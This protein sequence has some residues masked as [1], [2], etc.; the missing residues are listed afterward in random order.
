MASSPERS[1]RP[2][3]VGVNTVLWTAAGV[4]VCSWWCWRPVRG[5]GPARGGVS[6]GRRDLRLL[7]LLAVVVGLV[8]AVAGGEA[9]QTKKKHRWGLWRGEK[10]FWDPFLVLVLVLVLVLM[11][12]FVEI[13]PAALLGGWFVPLCPSPRFGGKAALFLSAAAAATATATTTTADVIR[14]R[15]GQRGLSLRPSP[16]DGHGGEHVRVQTGCCATATTTTTTTNEAHHLQQAGPAASEEFL[17]YRRGFLG[18]HA[19]LVSQLADRFADL[20]HDVRVWHDVP[21]AAVVDF[22]K[23]PTN[24]VVDVV[25]DFSGN[26]RLAQSLEFFP[27]LHDGFSVDL[28]PGVVVELVQ[29]Q[30]NVVIRVIAR[31]FVGGFAA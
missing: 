5:P 3:L 30:E 1:L 22:E 18:R 7:L 26:L 21:P 24:V 4:W 27:E 28:I 19:A 25:Y 17:P 31:D 16:G 10:R 8:A 15:R 29:A 23:S 12:E 9:K 2:S 11:L 14:R 6:G 13:G 20:G